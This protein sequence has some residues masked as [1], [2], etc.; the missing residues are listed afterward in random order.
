MDTL[1][2]F[3]DGSCE[4]KNPNGN[5]GIGVIVYAAKD[6]SFERSSYNDRDVKTEYSEIK[7]IAEI[8]KKMDFGSPGYTWTSNNVAEFDALYHA[9]EFVKDREEKDVFIFGDS[10]FTVNMINK[11]Y[12]PTPGKAYYPFA[13]KTMILMDNIKGKNIYIEWIPREL[14]KKADFLSNKNH[15][16]K[17]KYYK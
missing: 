17:R 3:F 4:P 5:V 12:A 1:V 11:V 7:K 6:F 15:P 2:I 10:Q 16:I 8:S 9:L 13:S 14:N